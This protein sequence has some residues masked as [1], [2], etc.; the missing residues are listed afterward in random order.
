MV[1]CSPAHTN[2]ETEYERMMY[3]LGDTVK[4]YKQIEYD[5]SEGA[6]KKVLLDVLLDRAPETPCDLITLSTQ[7]MVDEYNTKP[8][9]RG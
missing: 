5:A 9:L 1:K 2:T 3:K 7:E 6:R 8:S 4:V